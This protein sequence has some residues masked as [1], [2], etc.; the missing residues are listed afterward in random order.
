VKVDAEIIKIR[1]ESRKGWK[2]ED[3]HIMFPWLYPTIEFTT[4]DGDTIRSELLEGLDRHVG[5]FLHP[6]GSKITVLYDKNNPYSIQRAS[7]YTIIMIVAGVLLVAF[8]ILK[9][10]FK[11]KSKKDNDK[12]YSTFGK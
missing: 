8:I 6:V 12:K 3:Y 10:Y 1:K 9:L 4:A 5:W 2:T 11:S 7:S